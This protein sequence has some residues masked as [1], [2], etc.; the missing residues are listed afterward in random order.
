MVLDCSLLSTFI[1]VLLNPI[2]TSVP[3]VEVSYLEL[4]DKNSC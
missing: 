3:K 1:T 2:S 4:A